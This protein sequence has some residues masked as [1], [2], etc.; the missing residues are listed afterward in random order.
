MMETLLRELTHVRTKELA[1]E[2]AVLSRATKV[3][4]TRKMETSCV[5]KEVIVIKMIPIFAIAPAAATLS[6]TAARARAGSN[7]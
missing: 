6:K 3:N 5:V 2:R 7:L 1:K 4:V